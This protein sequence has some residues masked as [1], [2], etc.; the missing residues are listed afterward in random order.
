[1]LIVVTSVQPKV[2]IDGIIYIHSQQSKE[3][4]FANENRQPHAQVEL[5]EKRITGKF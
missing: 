3:F 5:I 2:K 4:I 1:M